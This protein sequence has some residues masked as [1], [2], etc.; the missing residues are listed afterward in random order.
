MPFVSLRKLILSLTLPFLAGAVGSF[1][2]FEA[3][4][5]WYATLQK[6]PLSPPNWVFGPV[7]TTLYL[8]MG[9]S[10]YLILIKKEKRKKEIAIELFLIQLVLNALWSILFFG[11]QNPLFAFVEILFLWAVILLTIIYFHKISKP[12]AYLLY[13]YI[14]WVSFAAYLNLSIL[15]LN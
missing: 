1:F 7:W 4:P 12:A 11:L 6:T 13:P 3:I 10:F 8:L 2:T 14:T 5:T 9:L 15:V